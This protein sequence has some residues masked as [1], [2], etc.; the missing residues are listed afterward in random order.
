MM[1][2]NLVGETFNH[3]YHG[4]V[5]VVDVVPKSRTKVVVKEINRGVGWDEQSQS[6]KG[7]KLKLKDGVGW[8][9]GQNFGFGTEHV[10]HKK[11]LSRKSFKE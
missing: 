1:I 5:E 9:R 11:E 7:V 6:Y 10:I 8:M 4:L 3:H 2:K